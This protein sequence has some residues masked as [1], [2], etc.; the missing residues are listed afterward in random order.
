MEFGFNFIDMARFY[1]E[2]NLEAYAKSVDSVHPPLVIMR[3]LGRKIAQYIEDFSLSSTTPKYTEAKFQIPTARE[4]QDCD[5]ESNLKLMQNSRYSEET[6]MLYV[7]DSLT[8]PPQC[9]GAKIIGIHTWSRGL[10]DFNFRLFG[11]PM[12]IENKKASMVYET[13][14]INCVFSMKD[15]FY[16]DTQTSVRLGEEIPLSA[17][18]NEVLNN[19]S[20]MPPP[21]IAKSLFKSIG[22][23][24]S[25]IQPISA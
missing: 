17:L 15:S 25:I 22:R 3:I 16:I 23:H 20:L 10:K 13:S 24:L 18:N 8:F 9:N 6:Y 21:L 11:A 2:H 1:E 14:A 7:G 12:L 4:M 19:A 5:K